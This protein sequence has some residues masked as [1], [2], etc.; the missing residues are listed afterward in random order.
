[1]TQGLL[2]SSFHEPT[3]GDRR[4]DLDQFRGQLEDAVF[5]EVGKISGRFSASRQLA[6]VQADRGRPG[7]GRPLPA[8]WL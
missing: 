7:A 1:M 2:N 8:G 3:D 4:R 6:A 5:Q